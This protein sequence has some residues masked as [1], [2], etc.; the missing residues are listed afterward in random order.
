M[1]EF[2]IIYQRVLG[3]EE[4]RLDELIGGKVKKERIE[5]EDIAKIFAPL[6]IKPWSA[7]RLWARRFLR[8][9][10][11]ALL[12]PTGSGK[13]TTLIAFSLL[14]KSLVILPN[15]TLAYQFA[16]KLREVGGGKR[17]V[18]IHSLAKK[19]SISEVKDADIV[20]STSTTISRNPQYFSELRVEAVF[21][22]DVDG[23]LRRS[24]T[25][26]I[27]L[28]VLGIENERIEKAIDVI[29]NRKEVDI[30]E[31]RVRDRQIIVSGATQTAKKTLRVKLL[32]LLFGFDIGTRFYSFRNIIDAYLR[33][34]G[35]RE[36]ELVRLIKRLGGGVIVYVTGGEK[37]K[38]VA[39]ILKKE[40]INA[41]A[42]VKPSKQIFER[43]ERGEL[44]VLVGT[45]SRRSSLVR[46]IDLP[47]SL[48]YSIFFQIPRLEFKITKDNFSPNKMLM[49]LRH[50][51]NAVEDK[52]MRERCAQVIKELERAS[53]LPKETWEKG[54]GLEGVVERSL[55]IFKEL[56]RR[57]EF[58]RKLAITPTSLVIPDVFAYIQASGRTSRL[59]LGGLTKGLSIVMVDDERIFRLFKEKLSSLEVE[60][61]NLEEI[62]VEEVMEEIDRTRKEGVGERI[63]FDSKLLVV[64]S[65]TKARTIAHFFGS[66]MRRSVGKISS[67]ECVAPNMFLITLPSIGH[68][69]DLNLKEENFGASVE[70]GRLKLRFILTK[71]EVVEALSRLAQDVDEV[72][73][74]TDPD[75]EGEKIA[76]DLRAMT[77][78]FNTNVKRARFHE[79][80]KRAIEE[81][82]RNTEEFDED[83]LKAQLARKVED[84]WIGLTLSQIL[85]W[86]FENKHLSAGR[87]QTPVL[88]WIIERTREAKKKVELIT[89]KVEGGL[90]FS[91]K[92]PLGSYHRLRG[93]EVRVEIIGEK[94]AELFPS[95]P[96]TTDTI[97]RDACRSLRIT[98]EEVMGVLQ[99]LFE[100][101]LCTY[102]R[103]DS[104]SVSP[105]GISIAR[106]Y[107]E[108]K[109]Y[110]GEFRGRDWK[111]EGA[112]ECIR[113]TRPMD[114]EELLENINLGLIK[115][116]IRLTRLHIRVYDLI[117]SRFIASQMKQA[118]VKMKR[119]RVKIGEVEKE[120]EVISE[121]KEAGY[122]LFSPIHVMK[123]EIREGVV[124][125]EMSRKIVSEYPLYS[126][127]EI[128]KMMKDRG[129]GRPSTYASILEKLKERKYVVTVGNALKST[130]LGYK[131]WN[132][133][134]RHYEPL[135]CEERTRIVQ[136]AMRM[137][138]E[139]KKSLGEVITDFTKELED[140]N[141]KLKPSMN[142]IFP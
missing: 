128:V 55:E 50:V 62:D 125:A 138:E 49:C 7:Q 64:E 9:E 43:F 91:F 45:S 86:K 20:V 67:F 36:E 124:K 110:G 116:P 51:L 127:A 54:E 126:E 85:Q 114:A 11:F 66:V 108:R 132:Y 88:G 47:K 32:Q 141:I 59:T 48:R 3:M 63:E 21:V 68:F 39:E 92:A 41:E 102:H 121:V 82:L 111:K 33:T 101:G 8:N 112:H 140:L 77:M 142:V 76:W 81:G 133:L 94:E 90:E 118:R 31:I 19:P 16:K 107:L 38:E 1:K 136:E 26:D 117:F 13:T 28:N 6:N 34:E 122:T 2:E 15:A 24:K 79:I 119:V 4:A 84:A 46:G 139:N 18:E 131:I 137:I 104:T 72:I 95:P 53:S 96:Y 29:K 115:L 14:K 25:I 129:I 109:G 98:S 40:G 23:F 30:E 71:P 74:A 70:D 61:V 37:A 130:P 73:I 113:P 75:A 123:G 87:V 27:A 83:L 57:E 105:V 99:Q 52:G 42:Y 80:T 65:P 134:V 106:S 35:E 17:I 100:S 120:I 12:A 10:S 103:T 60:L 5:Y 97:L 135:I 69:T 56:A 78:P 89:V 22:D 58:T 44:E 93:E